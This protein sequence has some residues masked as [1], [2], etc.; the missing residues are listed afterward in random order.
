MTKKQTKKVVNMIEEVLSRV[1]PLHAAVMVLGG[2]AASCGVVPPIT[3]LLQ[4]FGGSGTDLIDLLTKPGFELITGFSP[5][6]P[7]YKVY[8]SA[9]G[10]DIYT[11]GWQILLGIGTK[12]TDGT[13]T[14]QQQINAYTAK[15]GLW[16]SGAIEAAI[17][18]AL[19]SNPETFKELIKLPGK[20]IEGV[21]KLAS[22]VK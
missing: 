18:Y 6:V 1:D 14:T 16:C 3:R 15:L 20:A 22:L 7:G 8:E 12:N 17:M 19:V 10:Y 21:G 5:F 11:P 13:P 4:T 2:T 9:T